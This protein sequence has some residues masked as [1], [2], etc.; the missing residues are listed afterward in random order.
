MMDVRSYGRNQTPCQNDMGTLIPTCD[1]SSCALPP[2]RLPGAELDSAAWAR[3]SAA[4]SCAL[5]TNSGNCEPCADAGENRQAG[6]AIHHHQAVQP[7]PIQE[8]H[9]YCP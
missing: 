2:T 1:V 8:S 9:A 5:L 7:P 3:S 6:G 4:A